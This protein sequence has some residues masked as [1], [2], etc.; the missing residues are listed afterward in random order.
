MATSAAPAMKVALVSALQSAMPTGVQVS[1]GHPGSTMVEDLV[2]VMGVIAEQEVTTLATT[3]PRAETLRI[4]V[5]VS[6]Y[7]GGG[8]EVQ[9]IVTERAYALL[10]YVESSIR[11]DP[12][13]GGT[14]WRSLLESADMVEADD[15]DVLAQGRV[16]EIS[17]VI[18]AA[19]RL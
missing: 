15:P 2:A 3:R 16:T 7:R 8:P 19:A 1:Y 13:I 4:T 18:N 12:T 5:V 11:T 9:Q 14:V 10:A 17:A 6:C